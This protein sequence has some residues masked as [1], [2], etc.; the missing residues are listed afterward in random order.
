MFSFINSVRNDNYIM[1]Y[2]NYCAKGSTISKMNKNRPM[3]DVI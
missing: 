3:K 1:Y 2:S